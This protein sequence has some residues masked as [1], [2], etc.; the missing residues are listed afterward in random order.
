MAGYRDIS[1]I[2][3]EYQENLTPGAD[4]NVDNILEGVDPDGNWEFDSAIGREFTQLEA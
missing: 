3:E 4:H 1:V 2:L